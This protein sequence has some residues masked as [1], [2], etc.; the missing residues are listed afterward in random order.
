MA[1]SAEC[2]VN[3]ADD[4]PATRDVLASKQNKVGTDVISQYDNSVNAIGQRTGI[5]T[6]GTAFPALPSWLW[7]YDGL[8]QVINADRS[9]NPNDRAYQYDS[10][11]NCK[12]S[13]DSQTLPGTNKYT[14]N[15]LNQYTPRCMG[16]SPTLD[17]EY[18][19]DGN[20]TAYPLP[21]ATTTNRALVWDGENRPVS[22]TAGTTT[23]TYLYDSQSRRISK[24]SGNTSTLYLY[25]SWNCIAE[26]SRSVGVSPTLQKP[27][28]WGTD[29]SGTKQDAGGGLL[30]ESQIPNYYPTY[31]GN[32]NV[33]EYLASN[34]TVTAHFEYDP[35]GNTVV[36]PG[37]PELFNYRFSTKPLDVETGFY[38]YGYRYY[39]PVTG[40]WPSRDPIQEKGGLNLYKF[41][42]NRPA[43][44]IDIFGLDTKSRL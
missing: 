18:T 9:V 26:Y 6:R 2:G 35:F 31:D 40:K 38:Y 33:S 13:A 27:R 24:R 10:I 20:A 11:G 41:V 37:M 43:R 29:L 30:I 7:S 1:E 32:G 44:K 42:G 3:R 14:S 15:A 36:A 28:L 19:D 22:T 4:D 23:N 5:N 21:V 12:K 16:V 25:D 8:G 34:G 17:P 39:D